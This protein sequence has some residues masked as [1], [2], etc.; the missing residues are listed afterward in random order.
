VAITK[1]PLD[2]HEV[3]IGPF[4]KRRLEDVRI[5]VK[6]ESREDDALSGYGVAQ[7]SV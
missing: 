6:A 1:Q 7:L 2:V 4:S 5:A 3:S